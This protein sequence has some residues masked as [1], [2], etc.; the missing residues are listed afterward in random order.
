MADPSV[1]I[2]VRQV[3]SSALLRSLLAAV[4]ETHPKG[5]DES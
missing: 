5:E 2:G 1:S 4:A 3:K